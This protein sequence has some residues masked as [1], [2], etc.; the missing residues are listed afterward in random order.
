MERNKSNIRPKIARFSIFVNCGG[1]EE[2]GL[3]LG[4]VGNGVHLELLF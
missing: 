2:I 3:L 4:M 1:A